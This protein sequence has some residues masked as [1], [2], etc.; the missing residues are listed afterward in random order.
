MRI[1]HVSVMPGIEHEMGVG[2]YF[3]KWWGWYIQS[4]GKNW[5]GHGVWASRAARTEP[6]GKT[7]AD[8]R[9]TTETVT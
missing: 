7:P 8:W 1:A 6:T 2:V 4:F 9:Q 3:D 5:F